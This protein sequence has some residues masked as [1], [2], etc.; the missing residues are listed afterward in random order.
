MKKL[1]VVLV[2]IALA[3]VALFAGSKGNNGTTLAGYKTIDICT[4]TPDTTWRYSGVITA[5]NEGAI[6][7]VGFTIN[8]FIEYKTGNKWIKGFDVPVTYSG[9]IPAGKVQSEALAFPYSIDSAA[10]PGF[11]RNNAS[12]TI[13]NHSG[14]LG[15]PTGPNPKATYDGTLP[16]PA[17][18]VPLG[19]ITGG[20][21]YWK[22]HNDNCDTNCVDWPIAYSPN[23]T[24]FNSGQT[25]LGAMN[26][27]PKNG[28]YILAYQ[29][30]AVLLNA[31]KGAAEPTGISDTMTLATA[32][33]NTAVPSDCT[34]PGSCGLQKAWGAALEQFNQGIY[35]GGPGMCP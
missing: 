35:P 5:W 6:D 33:F 16:P 18:E 31:A 21:G 27:S 34:A 9:E 17:C 22:Q 25:W 2:L 29:Y 4:V 1:Q 12:L 32:W 3:S 24:F 13:M 15:K 8:D 11:I 10:L 30:I 20:A 19:C 28:Y 14:S 7:T 26:V 23:A